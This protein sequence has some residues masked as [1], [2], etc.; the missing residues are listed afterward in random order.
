MANNSVKPKTPGEAAQT[1]M[2]RGSSYNFSTSKGSRKTGKQGMPGKTPNSNTENGNQ[3]MS[4]DP[5]L[6]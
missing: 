2:D 4:T 3:R 6:A 1:D 5:R